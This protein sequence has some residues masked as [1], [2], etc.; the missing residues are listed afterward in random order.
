MPDL[1]PMPHRSP[2]MHVSA[3]IND[4]C[5]KLGHYENR[6]DDDSELPQTRFEVGSAF[7]HA[8]IQRLQHRYPKRYFFIGELQK[9]NISGTP[10]LMDAKIWAINE[11]KCT[12]MSTKHDAE[13]E[14]FWKYW[15]QVKA[16]CWMAESKVG[17]LRVIHLNGNYRYD[18]PKGSQPLYRKYRWDFRKSDLA[19]NWMMLR[20]HARDMR[21][22]E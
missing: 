11:M 3:I 14:K 19:E 18:D 10:D 22:P 13:S 6:D 21:E 17:I 1:A 12:W 9:D 5:L 16:Y 20:S 2:G 8:I 7:E 4:M 15:V